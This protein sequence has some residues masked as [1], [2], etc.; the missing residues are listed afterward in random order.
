MNKT[1]ALVG[2][3]RKAGLLAMG[4][5]AVKDA[6][7]FGKAY[8][9]IIAEDA[10]ENTKKSILNSCKYYNSN[11][12]IFGTKETIGHALGKRFCVAIAVTDKGFADNIESKLRLNF[13]GGDML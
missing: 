12:Y 5:D 2:L 7:R 3:A 8:I 1:L 10:S 13:N 6:I 11:H 4:E 9:T